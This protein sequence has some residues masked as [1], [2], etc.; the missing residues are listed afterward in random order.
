[1]L[2]YVIC[3]RKKKLWFFRVVFLLRFDLVVI[4]V[5]IEDVGH[6]PAETTQKQYL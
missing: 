6:S 3:F 4:V 2:Y 1:M 5:V